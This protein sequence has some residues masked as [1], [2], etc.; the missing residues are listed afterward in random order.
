MIRDLIKLI[1]SIYGDG[2]IKLHAAKMT[3]DDM[4]F[5]NEAMKDRVDCYGF[6][7]RE[8]EQELAE[9]TR[10][11]HVIATCSGTAA[12]Y[13]ILNHFDDRDNAWIPN[14]TFKGTLNAVQKSGF[15]YGYSDIN[16][17]TF[18]MNSFWMDGNK[19]VNVPVY[20]FGM[21][22]GM[23]LR[24]GLVIEDAC[25]ALGTFYEGKH[26]GTFGEAGA[27]S[28]NG[29]KIITCGGGGAILTDNDILAEEIREFIAKDFN[30]RMPALN[31]A[32]GLSQLM[33]IEEIISSKREIAHRYQELFEGTEVKFVKEPK[34]CRANYW[35]STI[36]LPDSDNRDSWF[37]ALLEN[38]IESRKGFE[39]LKD[40]SDQTHVVNECAGRVLCLPSGLPF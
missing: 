36:V 28:F 16:S 18:G 25:Q 15:D 6:Y 3:N 39:V 10:S 30:L 14:Y 27:L 40:D 19:V 13:A 2:K 5:V 34:N 4:F 29:N 23:N 32:L 35:L 7:V 17:E 8:F 31:A 38:E 20:L 33:R 24:A 37:D 22:Y 9:Y 12:L 11:K 21:P 1:R 26:A